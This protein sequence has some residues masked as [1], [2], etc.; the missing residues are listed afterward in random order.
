M[1]DKRFVTTHKL[2]AHEDEHKNENKGKFIGVFL[3]NDSKL[4]NFTRK[5]KK[6]LDREKVV[7]AIAAV[8]LPILHNFTLHL[9]KATGMLNFSA[10]I[11]FFS[12]DPLTFSF[13]IKRSHTRLPLFIIYLSLH[14]FLYKDLD[15][16]INYSF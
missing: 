11:L 9:F 10:I 5:D 13:G 15:S 14:I 1:C 8:P 7:L 4:L 3:S 2:K 16:S 6:K 12:G